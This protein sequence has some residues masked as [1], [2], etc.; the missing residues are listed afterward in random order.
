MAGLVKEL[1]AQVPEDGRG[2]AVGHTPLVEAAVFGLTGKVIEPLGECEGVR[3]T[4][5]GS[6]Q[7]GVEELRAPG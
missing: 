6:A 2:L 3:L 4:S 1:F 7:Y 5:D